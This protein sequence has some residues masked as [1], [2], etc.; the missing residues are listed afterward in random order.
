MSRIIKREYNGDPFLILISCLL[1]LRAKDVVTLPICRE[2]FSKAKTPQEIIDLPRAQLEKII[3][4]SGFYKRK[5]KALK[6]VSQTILDKY[7]GIV[8]RTKQELLS[9][10]GVGPKTANLVLA[11]AFNI[12]AI[13]VDTHVHTISNRLGIVHT[14][15]VKETEKALERILPQEYWI[16][17]NSLLVTWGQNVCLPVSPICSQCVLN[18]I[19]PKIGVLKRR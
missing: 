19:C 1:S 13:C 16:D 11:E 2:L 12:P 9:I 17:W 15:T 5:A 14:T 6:Q 7:N 8:P 4:K 10:Q 3:Y 18:D